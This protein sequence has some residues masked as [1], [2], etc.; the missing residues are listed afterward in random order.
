LLLTGNYP[1]DDVPRCIKEE[2]LADDESLDNHDR[3]CCDDSHQADDIEH[4]NDVEDDITWSSQGLSET[5]HDDSGM[6]GVMC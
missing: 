5:A 2:E 1:F 4:P 6:E 3:A